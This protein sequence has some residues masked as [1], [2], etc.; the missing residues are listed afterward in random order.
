M[1]IVESKLLDSILY[2]TRNGL[3]V[4]LAKTEL[5]AVGRQFEPYTTAGCVYT[6]VAPLR[7]VL[8]C[9]FRAIVVNYYGTSAGVCVSRISLRLDR[10]GRISLC[11]H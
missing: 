1:K 10:G 5:D 3:S 2:G 8:G 4:R 9:C 11:A 7:C 6:L